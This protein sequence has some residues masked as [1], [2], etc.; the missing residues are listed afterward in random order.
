MHS[1][2]WLDTFK[3]AAATKKPFVL[4]FDTKQ[5]PPSFPLPNGWTQHRFCFQQKCVLDFFSSVLPCAGLDAEAASCFP[6]RPHAW[7]AK[8]HAC[9]TRSVA[10]LQ[11]NLLLTIARF[12][13]F[14]HARHSHT[15]VVW[16]TMTGTARPS[17][18]TITTLKLGSALGYAPLPR[19]HR[20][21]QYRLLVWCKRPCGSLPLGC[22]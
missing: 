7:A 10:T 2:T 16:T 21:S 15:H 11:P 12:T 17:G 14:G 5:L 13:R 20:L 6:G 1:Q 22:R 9:V 8:S 19:L 4:L 3:A 18:T